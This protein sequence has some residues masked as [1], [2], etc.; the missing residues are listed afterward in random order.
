MWVVF[1]DDYINIHI[2]LIDCQALLCET[3]LCFPDNGLTHFYK[4]IH[5]AITVA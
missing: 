2:T 1:G 4:G 3:V 5:N